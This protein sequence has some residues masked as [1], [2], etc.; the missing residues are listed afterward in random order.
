MTVLPQPPPPALEAV[1]LPCGRKVINRLAKVALYE[2]LT[3]LGGG[4]P[5]EYHFAIYS[6][7]GKS[8]WGMVFTGNIQVADDH[9]TLGRDITLPK[10]LSDESLAP[11]RHLASLMRGRTPRTIPTESGHPL[12][13]AQLNHTGRQSMNFVGGRGIMGAPLGVSPIRVGGAIPNPGAVRD[14]LHKLVFS[15]PKEM[16]IQDVEHVI[17]HFVYGAQA[18]HKAGF[19][20]VEVH[21]AHGYLLAQFISPKSNTRTDQFSL[22]NGDGLEVLHRIVS[23]IRAA[24]PS[25]FVVGIKLNAADYSEGSLQGH[26]SDRAL[27][28]I[29]T[30]SAWGGV[31]FIEISGGDYESPDFINDDLNVTSRRQGIFAEMSKKAVEELQKMPRTM[32][33]PPLPMIMLTGGLQTPALIHTAVASGHAQLVGIGRAAI[34]CPQIPKVLENL[35]K[36]GSTWQNEPFARAPVFK[37]PKLFTRPGFRWI[38][39]SFSQISLIGAGAKLSWYEVSMRYLAEKII[40][41][42]NKEPYPDYRLGPFGGVVGMWTW[43][44]WRATTKKEE[45]SR[46]S[47][48]F[49][50]L[51]LVGLVGLIGRYLSSRP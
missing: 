37:K 30:I 26:Q 33:S 7:W 49:R 25:S 6:I 36:D 18:L 10:D 39:D 21:A 16:T 17:S 9:L 48:T 12:A 35:P 47:F 31:D 13:I 28:H 27:R 43:T 8:N 24:V 32:R 1:Q 19:D 38:W 41:E 44:A 50:T 11:Y 15:T 22:Q 29:L 42:K 51:L 45:S 4:P 5:N 2:H 3:V 34:L 46:I 40:D 20:G 23:R 14:T